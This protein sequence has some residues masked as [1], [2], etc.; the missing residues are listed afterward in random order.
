MMVRTAPARV[1]GA[2]FPLF[3]ASHPGRRRAQPV[4][5]DIRS[6][7]VA[8]V[9]LILR[10][11]TELAVYEKAEH[12]VVATPESL[13]RSLFGEGS[14]ARALMCEVDGEPAGFAVYFFSYSTW[15]ARQGLYLEDL[16]VSPRFR[17]AGAGLRLLKALARIAVDS[18]CGRF[19][20][21]VLDWNEPAIRFYE[22]VGAAPQSEWV[23]Y[24]LAGDELR[25]FADGAPV[26]AA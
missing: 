3:S 16:Y 11:I 13:E 23:R 8:D 20:W 26:S 21:S 19:E 22:S 7:T 6:A 14:P 4:Q 1:R 12:E 17:G 24:R 25:A 18:G 9:P 5:I 10:F 2:V 15:L